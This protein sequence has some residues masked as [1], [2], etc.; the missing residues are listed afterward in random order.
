MVST[1][2]DLKK[3]ELNY[4]IIVKPIDRSGSRGITKLH[5]VKGLAEAIDEAKA[6]GFEKEALV[7]EFAT[8]QEYSI[9][10]VSW[11]G[12]HHF[13]AM[14]HKFTTGAPH[15]IETG[16]ME[17]A[18]I[19][20]EQLKQVKKLSFMLWIVWKSHMERRIQS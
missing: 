2:D 1:I 12:D 14:T 19:S 4:P 16:H 13:L 11:K 5:D 3:I 20:Q 18:P 6:Q 9:E 8:G 10:C 15:F 17:P 7:E